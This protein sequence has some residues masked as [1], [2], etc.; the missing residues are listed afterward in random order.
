MEYV[1]INKKEL[2]FYRVACV[3]LSF[4]FVLAIWAIDVNADRINELEWINANITKEA[5]KTRKD[6]ESC[7]MENSIVNDRINEAVEKFN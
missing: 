6:I 2:V 4:L 1:V 3:V 7:I 5:I